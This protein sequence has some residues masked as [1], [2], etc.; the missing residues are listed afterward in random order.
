MDDFFGFPPMLGMI[1]RLCH[2]EGL[3]HSPGIGD[4]VNEFGERLWGQSKVV[5]LHDQLSKQSVRLLMKRVISDFRRDHEIGINPVRH[6]T[7]PPVSLLQ[8]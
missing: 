3:G 8:D 2:G 7:S 5:T 1:N 6:P 4:N